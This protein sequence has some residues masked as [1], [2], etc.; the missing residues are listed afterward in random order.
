MKRVMMFSEDAETMIEIAVVTATGIA[1]AV[2]K[3]IKL[4]C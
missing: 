3:L 2:L 4:Q 1:T